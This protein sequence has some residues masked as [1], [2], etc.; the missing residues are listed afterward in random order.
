MKEHSIKSKEKTVFDKKIDK[1]LDLYK[2]LVNQ[3]EVNFTGYQENKSSS[4]IMSIIKYN[5]TDISQQLC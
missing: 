2:Q 5:K 1:N 4:K 3:F